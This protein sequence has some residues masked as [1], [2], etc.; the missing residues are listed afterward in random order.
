MDR[1][2]PF[3]EGGHFYES[4]LRKAD[5]SANKGA[6]GR[7]VRQIPEE[8][9]QQILQAGFARELEPWEDSEEAIAEER[10]V[11]EQLIRRKFRDHAFQRQI[12]SAYNNTC[13]ITGLHLLNGKGRPEVEAAHIRPVEADGPDSVRNGLA[14]T[15]TVHW[16]FDRGLISLDE[17]YRLLARPDIPEPLDHWLV[18]GRQIQL[19]PVED[20][21][22]HPA[23]IRWHRENRFNNNK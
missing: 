9:F 12:R 1:S 5:G 15:G 18:A 13:A 10:P 11:I 2:V 17:D 8:E 4:L 19:P 16:L 14:L 22:P 23:F 21:R 6:F 20:L 7:A 3:R